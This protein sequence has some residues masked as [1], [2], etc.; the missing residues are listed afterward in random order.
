M[1]EADEKAD[2]Q[3]VIIDIKTGIEI[4]KI[5]NPDNYF[6]RELDWIDNENLVFTANRNNENS[7]MSVDV[8]SN[9]STVLI[10]YVT[11]SISDLCAT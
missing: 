9:N 4:K 1:I 7:L 2:Y 11:Q 3:I 6:I 10:P 5:P 8:N